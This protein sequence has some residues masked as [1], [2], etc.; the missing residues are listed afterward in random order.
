ML[1]RKSYRAHRLIW[2]WMTGD[3][4]E[5]EIDHINQDP[6]DNR[7]ENLRLATPAQN[8]ATAGVGASTRKG[9]PQKHLRGDFRSGI[10]VW[11][12]EDLLGQLQTEDEAHQA[13]CE[14]A[15]VL[16]ANFLAL[17]QSQRSRS[18]IRIRSRADCPHCAKFLRISSGKRHS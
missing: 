10:S 5:R 6:Y 1:D 8:V 15:E 13:Y 2:K 18:K 7:W 14:A 17:P 4:P 11:M 9:C 3:D 16:H 12:E